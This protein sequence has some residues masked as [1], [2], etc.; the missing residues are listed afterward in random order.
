MLAG[1]GESPE[2]RLRNTLATQTTGVIT[3]PPGTVEISSELQL[4]PGA[5]DLQIAGSGTLLKANNRFK[6]RAILV[7]EGARNI[8]FHD[9]SV[10]GN[11][12]V[13]EKPLQAAPPENAFRIYYPN[14]GV[15]FDRVQGIEITNVTFVGIVNFPILISR[16]SGVRIGHVRVEESGSRNAKGRNNT[17]GGILIEEGSSD[18]EVVNSDFRR[19]R[20]NALWTHS[21]YTSARCENGLF[22]KNR[23]DTIGRDAL[24]VGHA[25]HVRVEDNTGLRI[26]FPPEIVDV[27]NG[28]TPVAIDSSGN[29]EQSLYARNRF[30]EING[31][32]I[33]LDGFHD[34]AVKENHCI[35]R[36]LPEEYAFG[37][38]GIVMNNTNPDME[39]R[40]VEIAGNEIDGAKYGA[41]FLMGSGH[42]VTGN[43]FIHINKAECN[44]SGARFGCIYKA[45]EPHMLESGIYLGRG[46]VRMVETRGNVIRNNV[47]SGHKMK[48]RCIMAGPAVSLG[49]NTIQGNDCSDYSVTQ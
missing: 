3:L 16:S 47:I 45:D 1:C 49:A 31:K 37:H 4:A 12:D 2:A 30:D 29:V 38:F 43:R 9:F 48:T 14:N 19:I 40:N 28:G 5:H 15:L 17:T 18:F 20:G 8:H 24:Q 39:S 10:E 44:E 13:L 36:R 32:C 46:V 25:I 35:N 21:L 22:A 27:E 33:D 34:G 7:G 26:G 42:R 6:G 41:L 23:F 11:R